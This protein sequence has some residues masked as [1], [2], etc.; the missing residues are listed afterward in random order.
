MVEFKTMKAKQ[1]ESPLPAINEDLSRAAISYAWS[2]DEKIARESAIKSAEL[3]LLPLEL[4][5]ETGLKLTSLN[6]E[7][8][9]SGS[10]PLKTAESNKLKIGLAY[11]HSADALTYIH[12][13]LS[14]KHELPEIFEDNSS[15][16]G[17]DSGRDHP[18]SYL[19][20][21]WTL[22]HEQKLFKSNNDDELSLGVEI[23]I[24][25]LMN[26]ELQERIGSHPLG[27]NATLKYKF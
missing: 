18:E 8:D 2:G 21:K 9:D 13:S 22:G 15:S 27:V 3:A 6:D 14:F 12:Y 20:G 17:F 25:D 16:S 10:A 7:K 26:R 4:W 5:S 1:D 23:T 19:A 11:S 24:H